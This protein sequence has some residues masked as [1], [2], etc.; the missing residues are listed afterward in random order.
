MTNTR[1]L[2]LRDES[3]APGSA[4]VPWLA[5]TVLC[6]VAFTQRASIAS[7]GALVPSIRNAT[8]A[9]DTVIGMLVGLP[10]VCF[11]VFSPL[12]ATLLLPALADRLISPSAAVL[13]CGASQFPRGS[14]AARQRSREGEGHGPSGY[15]GSWALRSCK[16]DGTW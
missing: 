11:A 10:L 2:T 8:G 1:S 4:L 12:A 7:F 9:D 5:G 14:R 16:E 6:A 13:L 15:A 3:P